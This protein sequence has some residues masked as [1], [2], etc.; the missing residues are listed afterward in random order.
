MDRTTTKIHPESDNP[1]PETQIWQVFTYM[2]TLSF[3]PLLLFE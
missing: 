2:W 1:D 3:K